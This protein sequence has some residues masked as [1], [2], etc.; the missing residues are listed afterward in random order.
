MLI[1]PVIFSLTTPYAN[2]TMSTHDKTGSIFIIFH[3]IR[4]TVELSREGGSQS[5]TPS[6]IGQKDPQEKRLCAWRNLSPRPKTGSPFRW[7]HRCLRTRKVPGS[8]GTRGAGADRGHGGV[9]YSDQG[10]WRSPRSRHAPAYVPKR[11]TS[12]TSL[13]LPEKGVPAQR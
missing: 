10:M 2:C 4:G 1:Y 7:E 3:C 5:F 6:R 12:L 8:F 11:S 9:L 13:P